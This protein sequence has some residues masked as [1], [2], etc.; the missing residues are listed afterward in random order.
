MGK[1]AKAQAPKPTREEQSG[2][3]GAVLQPA[4]F[5]ESLAGGDYRPCPN[6]RPGGQVCLVAPPSGDPMQLNRLFVPPSPKEGG[7]NFAKKT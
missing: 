4:S 2:A 1:I 6:V 5:Y 7:R 3:S